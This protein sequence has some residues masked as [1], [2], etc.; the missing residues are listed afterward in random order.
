MSLLNAFKKTLG[1]SDNVDDDVLLDDNNE[2]ADVP[3]VRNDAT[4]N[5]DMPVHELKPVEIDQTQVESIFDYV[6]GVF[7]EALPSFLRDAVN[8]E[9]LRRKLYDGLD[10]S[11]KEYLDAVGRQ[12]QSECEARWAED[13]AGMRSEMDALRQ[14]TKDIEQQRFDIKQQQLSADRQRR[15]LADRVHDLEMHIASL[16][17]EREQFDLE[18][19]SL[20][21]KLKVAGIHENEVQSLQQQLTDAQAEILRLRN[22]PDGDNDSQTDNAEIE[23]QLEDLKQQNQSLTQQLEAAAE[24]DRIAT[25][26]LNGL[27]SK[28][29]SSRKQLEEKDL[30]IEKL[31][32]EISEAAAVRAEI[33]QLSVQMARF[34]EV[35]EKRDRKIARLKENC[36]TLKAENDQLKVRISELE[37]DPTTPIVS[38]DLNR[39]EA[40][41]KEP[42][43]D[44]NTTPKISDCDL[45][46]IE[47]SFDNATWMRTDPPETPSMRAGI[48]EA[49]FGYQAP[50]KKN[51]RNDNDAQLSLF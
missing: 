42:V 5:A 36:D 33:D 25:E 20:V 22:K 16:E 21:N 12:T 32:S 44:D 8:R 23:A 34:E 13:K 37:A 19:K 4:R 26:M 2:I 39:D 31:K 49:D 29:S 1:L 30:E 9:A 10:S 45:A 50:V 17:A 46:A 38:S 24:K 48:N 15:A 11:I 43:T 18:N 3:V 35:V 28:A 51:P 6:V 41:A 47:E 27:Q 40:P 14:K 7:N